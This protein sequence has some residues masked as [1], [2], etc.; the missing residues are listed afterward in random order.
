MALKKTLFMNI[1][2]KRDNK[3]ETLRTKLS[4]SLGKILYSTEL[5]IPFSNRSVVHNCVKNELPLAKSICICQFNYSR[6]EG[7]TGCSK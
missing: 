5:R 4:S 2:F 1:Q 3:A 7:Y 6:G